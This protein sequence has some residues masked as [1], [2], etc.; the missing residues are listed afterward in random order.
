MAKEC[1]MGLFESAVL[2]PLMVLYT[3]NKN[4]DVRVGSLKILLHVLEVILLNQ[5]VTTNILLVL[6]LPRQ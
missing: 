6:K 2:S 3:S 5:R 4:L 1:E